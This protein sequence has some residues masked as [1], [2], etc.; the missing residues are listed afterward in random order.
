M[1]NVSGRGT[2]TVSSLSGE[3]PGFLRCGLGFLRE[4]AGI[5]VAIRPR[6]VACQ[7][8]AGAGRVAAVVAVASGVIADEISSALRSLPIRCRQRD[9]HLCPS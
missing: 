7:P 6:A 4:V 9:I 3:R 1:T 8:V 2:T 5:I